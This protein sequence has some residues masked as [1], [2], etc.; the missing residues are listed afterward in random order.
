MSDEVIIGVLVTMIVGIPA[1]FIAKKRSKIK[2]DQKNKAGD[3]T[4][5]DTI[6]GNEINKDK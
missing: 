2:I 5:K 4:I 1:Y 6:I 3:N